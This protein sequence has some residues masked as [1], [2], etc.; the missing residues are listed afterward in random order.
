MD[1]SL[2]SFLAQFRCGILPLKVETGRFTGM[3]LENRLCEFCDRGEIEDEMHFILFCD[4]YEEPRVYLFN[5][6]SL[7]FG[8]DPHSFMNGQFFELMFSTEK[9]IRALA[10]FIKE[11][12]MLRK[13][14]LY[15][16]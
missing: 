2:R 10:K 4:L 1:R 12:F 3:P 13:Q 7:T 11:S 15:S 9:T 16:T 6:F 14:R 8:L 5:N